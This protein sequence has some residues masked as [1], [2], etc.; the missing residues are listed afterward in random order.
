MVR[1]LVWILA[2]IAVIAL[3]GW[4]VRR[5]F[6]STQ[7]SATQYDTTKVQKGNVVAKVTATGTLSALV[8]VQVGSQV[9]GRVK[10][11][12]VDFNAQV[13]KG[14]KLAKIDPQGFQAAIAQAHANYTAASG[15]VARAEAS[16]FNAKLQYDRA[17]LLVAKNLIAQADLDTAKAT[18]LMA[19]AEIQSA[20]GSVEQANAAMN[21]ARI[22]IGY[23]DI[24]SPV[25]GVVISRAVDVGQTVAAS[26]QAPVLFTIAENLRKMQVDTNVAEADVGK[27]QPGMSATFTV[28]AFPN[29]PFKGTVRQIRNAPVTVQNVVTYDAVIDVDNAELKLRPGMTATVTFIYAER[30]D[31][32]RIPNAALRYRP[33]SDGLGGPAGSGSGRVRREDRPGAGAGEPSDKRSVWILRGLAPERV[34]I[35]VGLSDGTATELVEGELQDGDSLVTGTTVQGGTK[36][37]SAGGGLPGTGAPG[38]GGMRRAF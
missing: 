8:T 29:S 5:Y 11:I 4:G 31:V 3:S 18:W 10:E 34:A 30:K 17:Q 7:S 25:D 20:K 19:Q 1:K 23:T 32:L 27:L 14:Q 35:K 38:G 26:L 37:A 12:F 28:D 13:S 6:L 21:T 22:N 36:P 33:P 15:N 16:A 9:S 2:A 24:L